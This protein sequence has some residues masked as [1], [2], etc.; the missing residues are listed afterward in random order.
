VTVLLVNQ[1]IVPMTTTIRRIWIAMLR[2][3]G[4]LYQRSRGLLIR[5]ASETAF[6]STPDL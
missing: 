2:A 6:V 1:A 5:P 3:V 4:L